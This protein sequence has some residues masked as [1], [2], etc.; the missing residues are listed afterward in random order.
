MFLQATVKAGSCQQ[1]FNSLNAEYAT[2]KQGL[3][4]LGLKTAEEK[5]GTGTINEGKS[6]WPPK[7]SMIQNR[8]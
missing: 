5:K 6:C 2:I 3:A 8:V 7:S 1:E 4:N